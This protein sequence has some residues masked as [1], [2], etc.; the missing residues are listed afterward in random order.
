MTRHII[1][2]ES[3]ADS[4][5]A[6]FPSGSY[7]WN[8]GANFDSNIFSQCRLLW[9]KSYVKPASGSGCEIQVTCQ[10]TDISSNRVVPGELLIHFF[11]V[12]NWKAIPS[13]IETSAAKRVWVIVFQ[14]M[15]HLPVKRH[16]R[17]IGSCFLMGS[18]KNTVGQTFY[19]AR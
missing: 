4:R 18:I 14:M 9:V 13:R 6:F 12:G 2:I 16:T 10:P 1:K 8:L 11:T 15:P 17:P 5:A 19:L 7:P 3:R